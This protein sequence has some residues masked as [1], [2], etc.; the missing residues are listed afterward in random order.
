MYDSRSVATVFSSG[1]WE[2][3]IVLEGSALAR[4]QIFIENDR[5]VHQMLE[6]QRQDQ[7]LKSAVELASAS[8]SN[9]QLDTEKVQE[10]LQKAKITL[11]KLKKEVAEKD[12]IIMNVE[13]EKD[14]LQVRVDKI[15]LLA[16]KQAKEF[17]TGK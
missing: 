12:K 16:E 6:P 3:T 13:K 10:Q 1:Q 7:D 15:E 8:N 5:Q 14:Q 4:S 17:E 2:R 9:Q 11:E